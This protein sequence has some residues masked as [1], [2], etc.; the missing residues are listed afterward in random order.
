MRCAMSCWCPQLIPH[1][2]PPTHL[3]HALHVTFFITNARQEPFPLPLRPPPLLEPSFSLPPNTTSALQ[4]R[5]AQPRTQPH[6]DTRA[7]GS[8]LRL[9][10]SRRS[11][12]DARS[13]LPTWFLLA[14]GRAAAKGSPISTLPAAPSGH[15]FS[16]WSLIPALLPCWKYL[17]PALTRA[18][19]ALTLSIMQ[20]N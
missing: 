8:W 9:P 6:G 2:R 15:G 19:N 10:S 4:R 7:A 14:D 13:P 5:E 16:P 3:R 17:C 20:E 1:P 18:L 12:A 11:P